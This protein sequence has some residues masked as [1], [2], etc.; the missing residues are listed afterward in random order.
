M[1]P[2]QTVNNGHI[3]FRGFPLHL[4]VLLVLLVLLGPLYGAPG[5]MCTCRTFHS[6]IQDPNEQPLSRGNDD[7][8]APRIFVW[9]A[10][11]TQRA[12]DTNVYVISRAAHPWEERRWAAGHW[13]SPLNVELREPDSP[14]QNVLK[15]VDA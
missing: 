1:I 13:T 2:D 8:G 15:M 10:T 6:S 14:A 5:M 9:R 12:Y 4:F 3:D 11:V 7:L